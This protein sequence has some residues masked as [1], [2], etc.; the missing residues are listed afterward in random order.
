MFRWL[1]LI[2]L[3]VSVFLGCL[4]LG[5]WGDSFF[6]IDASRINMMQ[7]C[8]QDRQIPC[9]WVSNFGNEYGVPVFNYTAPLAYYSG[10]VF[11]NVYPSYSFAT[12]MIYLIPIVFWSLSVFWL[13]IG[14]M[15]KRRRWFTAFFSG[16]FLFWI[17][18]VVFKQQVGIVWTISLIPSCWLMLKRIIINSNLLN[19]VLLSLLI[20]ILILV[21]R[22]NVVI[23]LIIFLLLI[24]YALFSKKQ[25]KLIVYGILSMIISIG[26][27]A[28][29]VIPGFLELNLVGL[30]NKEGDLLPFS[31]KNLPDE[32]PVQRLEVLTGEAEVFGFEETSRKFKFGVE[33]QD[34]TIIRL[35]IP[36][37]PEWEIKANGQMINNYYENNS[38]GLMTIILGEG[39]FIVEGQLVNTPI[40]IISN[41]VSVTTAVL[42][43]LMLLFERGRIRKWLKY[44][45]D[46]L[47][48]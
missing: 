17:L 43:A 42:V 25:T 20:A 32:R 18:V 7:L 34:R 48:S 3:V 31:M 30:R 19:A 44:Y 6:T 9:R 47:H 27:A 12:K 24:I 37:F 41:F 38:L 39:R 29:Y 4:F 10:W 36:Y 21:Q 5:N 14:R 2:L 8:W 22:E 16:I 1:I 26:L 15:D 13:T 46:A 33:S 11:Y 45:L 28:F 23:I 35:S 40:R